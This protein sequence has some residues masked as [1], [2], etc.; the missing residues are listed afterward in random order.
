MLLSIIFGA[1]WPAARAVLA[2]TLEATW[3]IFENTNTVIEAY[4]ES[5]IALNYFGDSVLNS[6]ADVL[7]FA[8]GYTASLLLATWVS[9]AVFL[10]IETVL[11]LTIRGSLVLNVVML[12]HPIDSIK[13]WQ[14]AG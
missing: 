10:G 8:L 13:A 2:V 11:L 1:R 12:L 14:M 3:E 6:M 4:R 5:T 7:A 9:A